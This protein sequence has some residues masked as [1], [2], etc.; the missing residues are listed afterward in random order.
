MRRSED[1]H[2]KG[3]RPLDVLTVQVGYFD[4]TEHYRLAAID[5]R[6]TK[7]FYDS[8]NGASSQGEFGSL[9]GEIFRVGGGAQFRFDHWTR[10][11]KH[12]AYVFRYSIQ[13][14]NSGYFL[15]FAPTRAAPALAT[16]GQH[17]YVYLDRES[18][19]VLRIVQEADGIPPDFP[20]TDASTTLDYDFF[21]V[22][23]VRYLLPL[24]AEV[25][26]NSA[27]LWA[28]NEIV[29]GDYRKFAGESKISFQ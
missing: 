10:L 26:M 24:S 4:G 28:R 6:P 20:I 22:A 16:V 29:F 5:H 25:R 12:A 2:D 9:M 21:D 11:R 14:S 23:G 13:A 7:V 17:G 15:Q 27:G 3:W 8:V 18:A 1:R 19:A